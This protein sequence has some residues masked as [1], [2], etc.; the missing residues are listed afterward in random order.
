MLH[1]YRRSLLRVSH[2]A[3]LSIAVTG[4]AAEMD[5]ER[6]P[7]EGGVADASVRQVDQDLP[8]AAPLHLHEA[9]ALLQ[10]EAWSGDAAGPRAS[11]AS[12]SGSWVMGPV[13]GGSLLLSSG[14][15][16]ASVGLFLE[17]DT[18]EIEGV[19]D[20]LQF[21]VPIGAL[22]TTI[23][24][25]DGAGRTDFLS[26]FA[27]SSATVFGLKELVDK[28]RPNAQSLNS[29]PS[30]H[31]AAAFSGAA[32]IYRRYGG[33]W[34][35]PAYLLAAYT[36]ASRV[37]AEKHFLDDV[38]SGASI[39]FLTNAF[40]VEPLHPKSTTPSPLRLKFEWEAGGARVRRNE[41]G[42]PGDT[43]F[44]FLFDERNNPTV[45]AQVSLEMHC[46]DRHEVRLRVAPFEVRDFG[47]VAPG[48]VLG[49]TPIP[50]GETLRSRYLLYDYRAVWRY[51]PE[52]D[53][54]IWGLGL[55]VAFQDTVAT[56][57]SSVG[58]VEINEGQPVPLAA[59]RFGFNF[60]DRVRLLAEAE[61][62]ELDE[63]QVVDLAALLQFRLSDH[64]EVSLVG[65]RI[66]RESLDLLET[67]L[68]N[69]Y[70]R[71]QGSIAV[72]YLF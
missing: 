27:I 50:A 63:T 47:Q 10:A 51:G 34:G 62:G 19:G 11:Q 64:W 25:D 40:L 44:T 31:T 32:F 6:R 49:G 26:S 57:T 16:A 70:R 33:R 66:E 14:I 48:T 46:Y 23:A 22:G 7:V 67:D 18:D 56:L 12:R 28:A 29:F 17:G 8:S 58:E 15:T 2:V 41:V 52:R 36:G 43:P 59:A 38:L 39:S 30:G 9:L 42:T 20:V 3:C 24:A 4:W 60:S 72:A 54:W 71:D 1:H 21:A 53:F 61:G 37:E 55:G 69:D 5:A 13:G 68:L 35:L 65:R 45:T